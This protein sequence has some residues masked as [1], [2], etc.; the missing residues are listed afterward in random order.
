MRPKRSAVASHGGLDGG[1]VADVGDEG[2]AVR[3]DLPLQR[4]QLGRGAHPVAG[5]VERGGDVERRHVI[6]LLGERERHRAALAVGGAGDEG[7]GA[8]AHA[9]AP[10]YGSR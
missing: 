2:Q 3:L 1:V 10:R 4:L 5:V 6:A 7:D 9:G 8:L